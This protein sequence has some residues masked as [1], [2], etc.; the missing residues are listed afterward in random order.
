MTIKDLQ[1]LDL[2]K[3][4]LHD[5]NKAYKSLGAYLQKLINNGHTTKNNSKPSEH[6][7]GAKKLHVLISRARL[8]MDSKGLSTN[9]IDR[10]PNSK[11]VL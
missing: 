3:C 5:I 6:Y 10:L 7:I 9:I 8:G 4:S 11:S 2:Y 1:N